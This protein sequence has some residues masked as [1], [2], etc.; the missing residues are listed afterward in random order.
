MSDKIIVKGKIVDIQAL[1]KEATIELS[2]EEL[3]KQLT[4]EEA[5]NILYYNPNK[6]SILPQLQQKFCECKEPFIVYTNFDPF[7]KECG[8]P[9][10][11]HPEPKFNLQS[12]DGKV[13]AKEFVHRFNEHS[14]DWI[15]ENLMIGWFA[16]AIM[17]GFDEAN[18]RKPELAS[19]EEIEKIVLEIYNDINYEPK[20]N[21][22]AIRVAHAL[23]GK[24]G[25]VENKKE[26][27]ELKYNTDEDA[28]G[29]HEIIFK[30]LNE[31]IRHLNKED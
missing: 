1:C 14:I 21:A 30:K 4:F 9:I 13:W 22:V 28:V 2:S 10:Q 17:A 11:S 7:C 27:E 23:V 29:E 25:K 15:D 16:N 3:A 24:V 6:K 12:M 18:R 8:K 19:E 20:G 26:I 31:I 5:F